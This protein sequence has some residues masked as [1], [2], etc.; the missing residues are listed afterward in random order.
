MDGVEAS[1]IISATLEEI[2]KQYGVDINTLREAHR[3]ILDAMQEETREKMR[4][5]EEEGFERGRMSS[6]LRHLYLS[7]LGFGRI[8]SGTDSMDKA[9]VQCVIDAAIR[10]GGKFPGTLRLKRIRILQAEIQTCSSINEVIELLENNRS[11]ICD[12]FGVRGKSFEDCL[13]DI[14]SLDSADVDE[15]AGGVDA[16][17]RLNESLLLISDNGSQHE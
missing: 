17:M 15:L 4:V 11:L 10:L 7:E 16:L 2:S 5:A 1:R 13:R 3:P 14:K 6:E 9:G 12:S 8:S